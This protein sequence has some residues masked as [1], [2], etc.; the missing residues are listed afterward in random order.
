MARAATLRRL[1]ALVWVLIYGGLFALVIGLA[2]SRRDEATGWALVLA[3]GLAAA[4]GAA[5]IWL[6]ARLRSDP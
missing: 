2:T 3:G 4:V 1:E 6:R 5:L